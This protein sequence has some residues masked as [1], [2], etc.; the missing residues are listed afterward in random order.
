MK[1]LMGIA[2]GMMILGMV[3]TAQGED[4]PGTSWRNSG[5]R[6]CRDLGLDSQRGTCLPGE[7]YETLC[8]DMQNMIKTCRGPNRCQDEDI[9]W[10]R[11]YEREGHYRDDHNDRRQEPC[12]WDF[13]NNQPCPRGY[14]NLDCKASCDSRDSGW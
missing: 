10:G 4:C 9:Q 8:D 5:G 11:R 7:R 12:Y 13:T 2:V 3:A 1:K 6:S 14:I